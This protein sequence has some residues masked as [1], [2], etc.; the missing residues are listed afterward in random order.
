VGQRA[1]NEEEW[2]KNKNRE[3]CAA[4]ENGKISTTKKRD[5]MGGALASLR[6]FEGMDV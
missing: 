6:I 5:E 2:Q 1:R 3:S 4:T